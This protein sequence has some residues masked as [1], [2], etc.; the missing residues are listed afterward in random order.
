M[1]NNSSK[2]AS[3]LANV[4]HQRMR[5][6]AERASGIV[7]ERGEIMSGKKLKLFSVPDAILDKSDYSVCITIQNEDNP[8]KEGERVL[9]VWTMDGEPVVVDRIMEANKYF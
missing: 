9:V 4:L 8:L 3:K 2:G 7:A 5:S 6:V 1:S